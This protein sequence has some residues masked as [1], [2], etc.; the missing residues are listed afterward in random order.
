MKC[1]ICECTNCTDGNHKR[2]HSH[3][4]VTG[5]VAKLVAAE[6]S[7]NKKHI[8]EIVD[9]LGTL[10]E[11]G[12]PLTRGVEVCTLCYAGLVSDEDIETGICPDCWGTD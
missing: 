11:I 12:E 6:R 10:F 4:Q 5:L 8:G 1:P 2:M 9:A 7:G 3:K